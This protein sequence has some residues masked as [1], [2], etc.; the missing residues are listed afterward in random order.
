MAA[1]LLVVKQASRAISRVSGDAGLPEGSAAR[2]TAAVPRPADELAVHARGFASEVEYL[3]RSLRRQGV[4]ASDAEDLA[5]DVLLVV[6][7]RWAEYD[8]RRPIRPWLAGIAYRVVHDFRKRAGRELP[9]GL[10]DRT[11]EGP[12]ALERLGAYRAQSLIECA[13]AQLS[14]SQRTLIVMADLEE[15]PIRQ[16]AAFFAISVFTLYARLRRA[17]Q[18]LARAYRRLQL[19]L[20]HPPT[21]VTA[22]A[23][24]RNTGSLPAI[25]A[26]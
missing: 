5:Q 24:T 16:V 7:R 15:Q 18:D 23:R 20:R 9:F 10:V 6:C 12:D 11:D 17:R 26:N 1:S 19:R 8:P 2:E 3:R 4:R 21:K 14:E 22:T 13:L 25:H